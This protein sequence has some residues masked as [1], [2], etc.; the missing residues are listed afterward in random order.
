MTA[1]MAQ[2]KPIS[3]RAKSPHPT[4]SIF[5][6]ARLARVPRMHLVFPVMAP[7]GGLR[8]LSAKNHRMPL[9]NAGG[10]KPTD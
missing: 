1:I 2:G 3:P 4:F 9:D 8:A 5:P 10:V 7:S 6:S